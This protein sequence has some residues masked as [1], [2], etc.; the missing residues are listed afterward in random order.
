MSRV[1]LGDDLDAL[2]VTLPATYSR[3]DSTPT[4]EELETRAALPT[5]ISA[6]TTV[7]LGPTNFNQRV[8]ALT[9][10]FSA[11][12]AASDTD[13]WTV[14]LRRIRANGTAV[15]LASLTTKTTGGVAIAAL[16]G[17]T[18]DNVAWP[19]SLR[20]LNKGDVLALTFTKT[21][22]PANLAD[23]SVAIRYEPNAVALV[24]DTFTRANANVLGTS[25]SGHTWTVFTS[26][27]AMTFGIV[28]NQ[29]AGQTTATVRAQAGINAGLADC[30][31]SAVLLS[32]ATSGIAVRQS[33]A[34]IQISGYL[35]NATQLFRC[36]A[37][38]LTAVS[39]FTD[40]LVAGDT[41]TITCSGPALT[42][43]RNGVWIGAA[44]DSTY[45]TQTTHGLRA[46]NPVAGTPLWD[47]FVIAA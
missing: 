5:A 43:Y 36:D 26:V 16:T 30:S 8:G 45:L 21:G 40:T 3:R 19:A 23:G 22:A 32:P 10:A 14:A 6:T 31:V 12:I 11:A 47:D 29:A 27:P 28:S 39:T 46:S 33:Q 24:R 15:T 18:L 4:L 13:F 42:V 25:D 35:H 2:H 20:H 17:W 41:V 37:D 38:A 34:G 44:S 1:Y 7:Y 9:L